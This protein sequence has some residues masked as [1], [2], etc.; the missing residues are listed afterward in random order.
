MLELWFTG[1][2][3]QNPRICMQIFWE[4]HDFLDIS[5]VRYRGTIKDA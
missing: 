4:I 1:H 5:E 3:D 2:V